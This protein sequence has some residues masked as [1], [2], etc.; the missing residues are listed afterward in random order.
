MKAEPAASVAAVFAQL[1]TTPTNWHQA[2]IFFLTPKSGSEKDE[3]I[4]VCDPM[5]AIAYRCVRARARARATP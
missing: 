4:A 5:V 2:T 3:S 1:G